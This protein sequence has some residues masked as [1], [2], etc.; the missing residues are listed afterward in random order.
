M[1]GTLGLVRSRPAG[2]LLVLAILAAAC[3]GTK[4]PTHLERATGATTTTPSTVADTTTTTGALATTV[5]A[6][7]AGAPAPAT[8]RRTSTTR[9]PAPSPAPAPA[10]AGATTN[11]AAVRAHLT[12]VASL[13]QPLAMAVR[14]GD[15]SLYVAQKSG[16]VV[17]LRSGGTVTILDIGGQVSTGSEQGLLG[18]AISPD[19]GTMV[20]NYTDGAGDTHVVAYGMSPAG[21]VGGPNE[22]LFVKQPFSNH[23]GGNV[24]FGPDGLLWIGLGD[25]GSGGDPD[26]NAQNDAT[27]LGKMIRLNVAT[28]DRSIWARGLR[29]P[30]R[31]SF[32]AA[33]GGL[34]IGDVGQ[35]AW[36]EI[37]AAPPGQG[38]GANYGWSRFEGTHVYNAG[39]AAPGAIPPV[40]EYS[41]NGGGCS[42]TGGYVYRGARNPSMNGVYL[43]GDFCLGHVLGMY[44]GVRDLGLVV[45]NL[46]SFGQDLNGELYALSLSGPVY[47]I[48]PG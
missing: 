45:P 43:F 25:G 22:L 41:H 1:V 11:L 6:A 18:V 33:T 23:N 48:D 14:T 8:T 7:A 35:D 38:P 13:N 40:Y 5:P 30:W 34:F 36:E 9:R 32:D 47:R 16:Q 26:N 15:S 3:G 17:A 42:V 20:I 2:M 37:D 31:Y 19:G 10:P 27:P 28:K 4:G 29:N 46:S 39:R 24:V 12:Q 21:N 44:G